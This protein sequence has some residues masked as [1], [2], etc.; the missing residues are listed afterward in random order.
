M[1][2]AYDKHDSLVRY[3][4]NIDLLGRPCMHPIQHAPTPAIPGPSVMLSNS[5]DNH[6][7]GLHVRRSIGW[8]WGLP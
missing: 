6:E 4:C 1:E 3:E 2:T 8:T 5:K 7:A